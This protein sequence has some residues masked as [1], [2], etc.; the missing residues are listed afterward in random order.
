M[1]LATLLLDE[2]ELDVAHLAA[3]VYDLSE[4]GAGDG[5]PN[6]ESSSEA[7]GDSREESYE[8]LT[9]ALAGEPGLMQWISNASKEDEIIQGIIQAKRTGQ[10]KVPA[11]L[12]KKYH[13]RLEMG[14]CQVDGDLLYVNN[15]LFVPD[16]PNL[17]TNLIK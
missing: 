1:E 16:V 17:R 5:E 10:R 3:L 15:R 13:L 6:E 8:E 12:A 7:L 2:S 9:E 11:E 14:D 4:Q